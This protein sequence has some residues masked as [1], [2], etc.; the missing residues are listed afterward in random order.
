[1]EKIELSVFIITAVIAFSALGGSLVYFW[2]SQRKKRLSFKIKEQLLHSHFEQELLRNQIEIQE[3]TF[4]AIGLEIHDNIGQLLSFAKMNLATINLSA[5]EEAIEKITFAK[6]MLSR[7]IRD[8]RDLA[9]SLDTDFIKQIGLIEAIEHLLSLL[10][11]T[12]SFTTNVIVSGDFYRCELQR[13]LIV[14]RLVQETLN[15]I[16]KHSAASNVNVSMNYTDKKLSIQIIDDGKGFDI[17]AK[18]K[19]QD[20]FGLGLLNMKHRIALVNGNLNIYSELNNGT[21]VIIELNK[22]L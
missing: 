5:T 20:T 6:E 10:R 3:E 8:L 13:E 16:A 4:K 22:C 2:L 12:S 21:T 18:H 7:S 9:K 11:K 19:N 14:Y 17:A 1:M 15:N